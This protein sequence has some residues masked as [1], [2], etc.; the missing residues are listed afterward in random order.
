MHQIRSSF[1]TG[2]QK[3]KT[4]KRRGAGKGKQFKQEKNYRNPDDIMVYNVPLRRIYIRSRAATEKRKNIHIVYKPHLM[5][6]CAVCA[7]LLAPAC[8]VLTKQ[9][10]GRDTK[11]ERKAAHYIIFYILGASRWPVHIS[12]TV[13]Y[14]RV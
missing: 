1:S 10:R 3:R 2:V 9:M 13:Y 4:F 14:T 6:R 7:A 12:P 5:Q 8:L 11:K